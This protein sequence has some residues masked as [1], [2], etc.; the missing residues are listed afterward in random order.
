MWP[1]SRVTSNWSRNETAIVGTA[2]MLSTFA[3][4]T[5]MMS[6]NEAHVAQAT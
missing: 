1:Q 5:T 3:L 4:A 6:N 2:A